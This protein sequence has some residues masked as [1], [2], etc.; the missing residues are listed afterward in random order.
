MKNNFLA[1]MD[2]RVVN[3]AD[4]YIFEGNT[5]KEFVIYFSSKGN[6]VYKTL[7]NEFYRVGASKIQAETYALEYLHIP[8]PMFRAYRSNKKKLLKQYTVQF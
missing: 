2:S 1:Q 8:F 4:M 3:M 7:A 5:M 6:Q